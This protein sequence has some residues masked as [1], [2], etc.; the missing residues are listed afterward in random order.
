MCILRGMT[1]PNLAELPDEDLM[2]LV[3]GGLIEP[4]AAELFRRHNKPLFNYLAW[5][6]GGNTHEAE[7]VTQKT[8]LRILTRCADYR[9]QAAFRTYLIQI[10]RNIW[11]D[12]RKSAWEVG[13]V[14]AE[15]LPDV[16]SEDLSPEAELVLRQNVQGVRQ[17]I[18]NLPVPQREA[19]VLRFFHEMSLEE[20]A[21]T[22]GEGFETVKSRLRYAY[23]RLRSE[24][25]A[26][27]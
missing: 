24:L 20:I 19:I 26:L 23:G 3:A 7:D 9:P 10:A 16:P 5:L 22:V 6:C 17:A 1:K 25:E 27:S 18:L 15:E 11:L 21:A 4:P 12:G 8:W 13:K 2:L 14:N